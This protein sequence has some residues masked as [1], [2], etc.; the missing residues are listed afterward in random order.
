MF[1]SRGSS[2]FVGMFCTPLPSAGDILGTERGRTGRVS[3]GQFHSLPQW[4]EVLFPSGESS[5]KGLPVYRP[6]PVIS[7]PK[8]ANQKMVEKLHELEIK[9]EF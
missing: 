7:S 8:K 9:E 5:F 6:H 4:K 1:A 2:H 3:T